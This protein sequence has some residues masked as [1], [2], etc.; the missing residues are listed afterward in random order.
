MMTT[1]LIPV[2]FLLIAVPAAAQI[3]A[4]DMGGAV[5]SMLDRTGNMLDRLAPLDAVT[6]PVRSVGDMASDRLNRLHD[7][8]HLHR[9]SVEEDE[10]GELARRGVVLMLDGDAAALKKVWA[11]GFTTRGAEYFGNLGL[12]ATE[13]TVPHDL[14]LPAA[15]AQ[16]RVALPGR[17]FTADQLLFPSGN[18]AEAAS[19]PQG[20]GKAAI[21][22]PVG[23]I[24]GGV[25]AV[26]PVRAARGFAAGAPS[27]SDH[28]TAVASLLR[29]A[30]VQAILSADVYGHD[31][32][33]GSAL[34]IV[35]ALDWMQGQHVTV[36][37]I[38]LAGPGNPLLARAVT[39][40][41]S[42]GMVIVAAV[43]NDGPAA[44]PA[45]PASYPS[46]L[47][48]TGVDGRNRA[49]IE[50]G[51]AAH[52]DYAAPGA[53]MKA[54]DVRGRWRAMRGTS[55]AAPLVAA[56]AAAMRDAGLDGTAL[57]SAL[58]REARDLGPNGADA[59]YGRGLLCGDCRPR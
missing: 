53:D 17:T 30:G 22:T 16:L 46:I 11:L 12:S 44:P 4:P 26:V 36:V 29:Y 56:R 52:L 14:S 58:D 33:G 49:L 2:L 18:A 24:D 20:R 1:R 57:R 48:V 32:A 40:C 59:D 37:S 51:R 9:E 43:G 5:G 21:R 38:S 35:R 25:G 28:G 42:R 39:I 7:F 47:A 45:Y 13:L 3:G 55:F 19:A 31:P 41:Q 8:L 54:M 27:A 15:L 10:R 23:L 6:A 50:A 34:A